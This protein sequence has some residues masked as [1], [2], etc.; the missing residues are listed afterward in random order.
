MAYWIQSG[1]YENSGQDRTL[2]KRFAGTASFLFERGKKRLDTF[3][4][5]IGY[6]T[7]ICLLHGTS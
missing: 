5:S 1:T 7:K 2:R 6:I 4:Q 3:L